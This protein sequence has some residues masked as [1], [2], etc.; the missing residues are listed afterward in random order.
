MKTITT[1][2]KSFARAGRAVSS[3]SQQAAG[4]IYYAQK[5]LGTPY[6]WGGNGTASRTDGSTARG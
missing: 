5:K 1:L 6:L 2:E 4:A 3:P